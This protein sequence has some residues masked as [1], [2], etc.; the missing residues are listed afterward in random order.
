MSLSCVN[1]STTLFSKYVMY[2]KTEGCSFVIPSNM[3][4]IPMESWRTPLLTKLITF[5]F[6]VSKV[7]LSMLA[8][9]L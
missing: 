1:L 2:Y 6:I 9:S 4:K 8:S 3:T 5:C 7:C